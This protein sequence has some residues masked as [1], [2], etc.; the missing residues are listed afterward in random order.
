MELSEAENLF[1]LSGSY[2]AKDVNDAYK[3]LAKQYHPDLNANSNASVFFM[4]QINEAKLLLETAVT[5]GSQ[6]TRQPAQEV[7]EQKRNNRE[8]EAERRS[9]ERET[10]ERERRKAADEA[11]RKEEER[12]KRAQE[13]ERQQK[14]KDYLLACEMSLK[15]KTSEGHARVAERF[16]KLGDYKDAKI[17]VAR[18]EAAAEELRVIEAEQTQKTRR[19]GV[20]TACLTVV[21]TGALLFFMFE[22][23]GASGVSMFLFFGGWLPPI[24]SFIEAYRT[25]KDKDVGLFVAVALMTNFVPILLTGLNPCAIAG[26]GAQIVTL[27]SGR[28]KPYSPAGIAGRLVMSAAACALL[29]LAIALF[30]NQQ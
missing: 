18:H 4:Q 9:R 11:R 16:K 5:R 25:D 6:E 3:R 23:A 17:Y 13:A 8:K 24:L 21:T 29:C 14:E 7:R 12:K 22:L 27:I 20:L 1:G 2:T 10:A 28:I 26:A 30:V 19:Y 15:V